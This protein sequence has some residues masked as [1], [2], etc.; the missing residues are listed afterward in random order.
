M[1]RIQFFGSQSDN[2]KSAIQNPKWVGILAIVLTFVFGA[3]EGAAQQPGKIF[4]IGILDPSTASGSAVLWEA[5][6]QELS[7]LGWIEGKNIVFEYRFAEQKLER[8]PALAAELVRLK[9]D[10][11]LVPGILPAL[12]AK[13]AT[14]TIPIVVANAPDPVGARLVASL[15]RP[16]GNITGL[17]S[18]GTELNTK[19]LEILKDA[20]PELARVGLLAA[21]ARLE[22]NTGLDL[23]LKELRAAALA[24]KLKL[25][26]IETQLDPKGLESAFQTAKQKQVGAIMTATGSPFFAERKRIVE[27]AGKYRLPAIYFQKEFVDE[28][29]L[30][31]YGADSPDLYRRAAVYVDKILKGAKPADLPVQQATKFEFVINL[32]AAKQIGLTISPDMLARANQVI[33]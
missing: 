17:A 19:R 8:L 25:E 7:K 1:K 3:V 22:A 9:A 21:G 18:L 4:R 6:R 15:A 20:V 11:I 33:K 23:Q 31:F 24:L 16:G 13:K 29:G 2:P 10:L 12:A 5:F 30:M 14:P 26:E 28:G 27:L 32:K